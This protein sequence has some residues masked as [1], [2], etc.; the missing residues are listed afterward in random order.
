M[1]WDK[2]LFVELKETL[3]ILPPKAGLPPGLDKY[4][5]DGVLYQPLVRRKNCL[6]N[7]WAHMNMARAE[8]PIAQM[9][10]TMEQ[11]DCSF[12]AGKE[13]KTPGWVETGGDYI[14]IG[15]NP[16]KLRSFPN[17]YPWLINHLNIVESPEH[18]TSF[19]QLNDEEELQAWKV[20]AKI[21]KEIEKQGVMPTLFRN[22]GWGASIAHYHWQVG[23]LPYIPNKVQEELTTAKKFYKQWKTNIFDALIQSEKAYGVRWIDE[24]EYTA[25]VATYAPRTAFEVWLISK[26]PVTTLAKCSK[27]QI[28]SLCTKLNTVLRKLLAGPKIDTMNIIAHQLPK[29][30]YNKYYRLHLEIMPFKHLAGAER[31]FGEYAI[32]VTPE[33][34]AEMLKSV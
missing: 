29:T 13:D 8:R 3:Q 23:G 33:K 34:V 2:D 30:K 11:K 20:A 1:D 19:S 18:K 31:G 22:H 32:E 28:E 12:C 6:T 27:E 24:D 9:N 10:L 21:T 14:R 26:V 4:Y 25:V 17:L 16:W 5:K 15:D 7:D